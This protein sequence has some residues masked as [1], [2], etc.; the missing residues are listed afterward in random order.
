[1]KLE[2]LI[3]ICLI[4]V[5]CILN[6]GFSSAQKRPKEQVIKWGINDNAA[7]I[8]RPESP[9]GDDPSVSGVNCRS[10]GSCTPGQFLWEQ[11]IKRD[12]GTLGGD[13]GDCCI[14]PS[15]WAR[16]PLFPMDCETKEFGIFHGLGDRP[17][18]I[19]KPNITGPAGLMVNA[20]SGGLFYK[21]QDLMIPGNG[22][23]LDM[24]FFYNSTATAL[25]FGFGPGWTM[26]YNMICKPEGANVVIR[27]EDGR[28]DIYVFDMGHF[29]P[30]KGI[31]DSLA[32][33][34]PGKFWLTTKYGINYYFDDYSHH[35]LTRM[36]D[37]NNNEL[38]ISY[39]DSL[40]TTITDASG[41]S[42]YLG[43]V[44]GHLAE[45]FDPNNAP[46]RHFNYVYDT[47]WN[48]VAVI[49]P[50]DD[51]TQYFYDQ[52]R[53]LTM[54][55]DQLGNE[56]VVNYINCSQV[57]S[58]VSSMS[59][60]HISYDAATITTTVNELVD[61]VLQST[62][63]RFDTNGNLREKAG[64][65][66]G[67]HQYYDYD[68]LNNLQYLTDAN[69]NVYQFVFGAKGALVQLVYPTG[70]S[71]SWI[72]GTFNRV[73]SYTDPNGNV[74]N[75][76]YDVF[77][78]LLTFIKPLGIIEQFTYDPAG[79]V[80]SHMDGRG[81]V[82][83]YN[84][85]S[86]GYVI[87][88]LYADG[89]AKSYT[90]DNAGNKLSYTDGNN[91]TTGYLYDMYGRLIYR[92]DAMNFPTF[93]TYNT[94]GDLITE[95]NALGQ[96]TTWNYD[97]L[98]NI[99]GLT[100]AAGTSLWTYDAVGNVRAYTDNN[101]NTRRYFY[102]AQNLAVAETDPMN[103]TRFFTYDANGNMLG[104]SDF[105]GNLKSYSYDALNRLTQVADA[106]SNNTFL[107]YDNNGNITSLIDAKG[108]TT[109]FVYDGLDRL[110][111]VQQPIGVI[112]Y[113][114]DANDNNTTVVDPLGNT[115]TSF[116]N[117]R[118]RISS[119]TD[120][121]GNSTA[122]VYDNE[123]NIVTT[124]DRNGLITNFAYDALYRNTS[125]TNPAGETSTYVYDA[126]GNLVTVSLPGGNVY[127]YNYDAVHRLLSVADNLGILSS[128]TYDANSN[129]LTFTDAGGHLTVYSYD[130][131]NRLTQNMDP[132]GK[133]TLYGYDNNSNLTTI[134]DR[135]LGLTTHSYDV[136]GRETGITYPAGNSVTYTYDAVGNI[137]TATD[138][139]ANTTLYSYDAN[140][141]LLAETF[142]DGTAKLYTYNAAD[143]ITSRTDNA[144]ATTTYSWDVLHRLTGRN[145]PGTNDDTY[146][147]D[148]EGRM[149]TANNNN[150]GITW[151]WDNAGRMLSENLNGKT[152]TYAYNIPT[153]K[154]YITYPGGRLIEETYDVRQRLS[155]VKEGS[156]NL[157]SYVHDA[158]NRIVTRTYSNGAVASYTYNNNDWV[159]T[160][161][162]NSGGTMIPNIAGFS[163]A[164]DNEGN[165]LSAQKQHR[166]TNSELY[167]FDSDNR[168][169]S[170]KEG[171]YSGGDIPLPLTQT[172]FVYD[173]AQNRTTV[174]KDGIITTYTSNL[175][176]EYTAIG[177]GIP[178]NPTY[179]A[180][181]NMITDGN[182]TYT[183]DYE[184]RLLTVDAGTT[185]AYRYDALG[186]RV[187]KATPAGTANYYFDRKKVIEER[188]AG[189]VVQA[190]YVYGTQLDDILQ[191]RRSSVDYFYHQNVLGSVTA[192][193]DAAGSIVERYEY[194]GYG[195]PSIY[196]ASYMPRAATAVG[197]AY[198][199]TGREYDVETGYY[200]FRARTYNPLWGR[201]Q[202]RD[203][204][205]IWLDEV[206]AGNGYGYVGN[207]P[208]IRI[209]PT[210]E[211]LPLI[212]VIIAGAALVVAVVDLVYEPPASCVEGQINPIREYKEKCW[213]KRKVSEQSTTYKEE[214]NAEGEIV[215][216][217]KV[218]T[219]TKEVKVWGT[220][221]VWERQK[222][223]RGKW[224]DDTKKGHCVI[225]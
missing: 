209:D 70:A 144:M 150:G 13:Q 124:T 84:R 195:N 201:F 162:H 114:Y 185:A 199:F 138:A 140:N 103:N 35:R 1:M 75:A 58:I 208:V 214:K 43:F 30:P 4:I 39:T 40:P 59:D 77:G 96:A 192:V 205:G 5:I 128:Y 112:N 2:K 42:I 197:N 72:Y 66:C 55:K 219:K 34:M 210:G 31:F 213:V 139:N 86:N 224:V 161:T 24:T 10:Q 44:N 98:G 19:N 69:G 198:M 109:S 191:M 14:L 38:F 133:A 68:A 67:Y 154:R 211:W 157:A 207:N 52:A 173:G 56:F 134:V 126:A 101:G 178:V 117:N 71:M 17:E 202:Q 115:T 200:Y 171:T 76:I 80:V 91:N 48:P 216:V 177:T 145:Y 65:C 57:E 142:A 141:N 165:I 129:Q 104:R 125:V 11:E 6:S 212:G 196:D 88:I 95:T 23:S 47:N 50:E 136:L 106:L 83:Q 7:Y 116:F 167:T 74:Y 121:M 25:D 49:G 206:N 179:D 193:T 60:M 92:L 33:Y 15:A 90:W 204:V 182:H 12:L 3:A 215:K 78:N 130:V 175:L 123:G 166:T 20:Y 194:D 127:S 107:T 137:S 18:N 119:I 186:R 155:L 81:I 102:N 51:T 9:V 28:K 147:Y 108:N 53:S 26:S 99:T 172:Q 181:G 93:F 132:M 87:Q 16:E 217:P 146:T 120:A 100:T 79:N 89:T 135:N 222:C 118:D 97:V 82:T 183:Y 188:N 156:V 105:S 21:R 170:F 168:L 73:V 223:V 163:Y 62:M 29:V 203:P 8:V 63:F 149:L 220:R 187:Q 153:N 176:N 110:T 54:L 169:V 180:N 190:T 45:I 113:S 85:N 61:T 46:P 27:R 94:R 148:N 174:V 184:N 122:F 225:K 151:T 159:T 221:T 41:R 111:Q 160:L 37:P 158:G 64:G 32:E 164:F 36:T 22:F 189:N 218:T 131:L 152:T 143:K